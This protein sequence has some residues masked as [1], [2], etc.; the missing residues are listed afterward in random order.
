MIQTMGG[1]YQTGLPVWFQE[2]LTAFVW[3]GGSTVH[4]L[5][6]HLFY[7]QSAMFVEYLHDRDLQSFQRFLK[8][9]SQGTP[10]RDA[11]EIFG[12]S[13]EHLRRQ[14]IEDLK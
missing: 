8:A 4:G 3:E 10:F 14:F 2:G 13:T 9:I 1:A 12:G 11:V 6:R 5:Q 7:R